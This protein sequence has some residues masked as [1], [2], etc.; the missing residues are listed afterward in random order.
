MR[1]DPGLRKTV[2][3]GLIDA[4][5]GVDRVDEAAARALFE[6]DPGYFAAQPRL[7]VA[8]L[9]IA[10]DLPPGED[11]PFAGDSEPAR[12]LRAMVD[13]D[14]LAPR[15]E[16]E[17]HRVVRSIQALEG[18]AGGLDPKKAFLPFGPEG[19][20]GSRFMIAYPEALSK[21]L[22]QVTIN[23]QWKNAPQSFAT[24]T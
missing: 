14:R 17:T 7:R 16:L 10:A 9:G 23:L 4:A 6:Q 21:K 20:P 13:P 18:D 5:S 3:A 12:V 11:P 24:A 2:I 1:Q 22:S 19:T 15:L 8:A